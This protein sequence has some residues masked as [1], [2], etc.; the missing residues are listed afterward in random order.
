MYHESS[1]AR[2]SVP[3][4]ARLPFRRSHHVKILYG[5]AVAIGVERGGV[6]GRCFGVTAERQPSSNRPYRASFRT[7]ASA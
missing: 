3:C 4:V 2:Q 6:G 5:E 7:F 1:A